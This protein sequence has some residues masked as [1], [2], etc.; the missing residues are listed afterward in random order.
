MGH[1]YAG[2]IVEVG[3]DV[4]GLRVGMRVTAPD[5][6]P[7]SQ[8]H[9]CM[10]GLE[11]FCAK[12]SQLIGIDIPGAYAEYL[13]VPRNIIKLL[14]VL[15]DRISYEAA[16]QC[17][18]LACAINGIEMSRVRLGDTV[19]VLGA[20]PI[21]LLLIQ[22]AKLAGASS[23][24]ACDILQHRVENAKGLGADISL[25]VEQDDVVRV[26]RDLT[27]DIGAAAVINTAVDDSTN[28]LAFK[29]VKK[30]GVVNLFGGTP[31]ETEIT[32][33]ANHLHYSEIN[34]TGS[35]GWTSKMYS[36]A[37]SLITSGRI[38]PE[39]LISHKFSIENGL[40]AWNLAIERK[41]IKVAILN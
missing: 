7:C 23:V 32:L 24:V 13:R 5:D 10:E 15:P 41:G 36:Q 1:E 35:Y 6:A 19:V 26:V 29:L 25:N 14:K 39:T 20:G 3:A 16:S 40:E 8:C 9:Y 31:P 34:L 30:S 27:D 21:G 33:S 28:A 17:E 4:T 11:K 37:F 18:P 22:L 12:E 2:E 38:R